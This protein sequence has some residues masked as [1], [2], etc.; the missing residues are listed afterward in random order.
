MSV[1][2]L[3]SVLQVTLTSR[4]LLLGRKFGGHG[5]PGGCYSSLLLS[6]KAPIPTNR[7]TVTAQR[8]DLDPQNWSMGDCLPHSVP[9]KPRLG[10]NPFLEQKKTDTHYLLHTHTHSLPATQHTSTPTHQG[11]LT[12]L[13]TR[14]VHKLCRE[15]LLCSRSGHSPLE[16]HSQGVLPATAPY[17][18]SDPGQISDPNTPFPHL[19]MEVNPGL[20]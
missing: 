20:S 4:P 6:P 2:G 12:T 8:W 7:P 18:L 14:K 10:L 19:K 11:H 15:A 1:M 13:S 3:C 17:K 9:A 16:S 5:P